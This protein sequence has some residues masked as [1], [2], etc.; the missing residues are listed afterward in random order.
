M[1]EL[2]NENMEA[3]IRFALRFD[4]GWSPNDAQLHAEELADH[5]SRRLE[6]M[7]KR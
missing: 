4:L 1:R 2:S 6:Y 5:V 3:A 7:S